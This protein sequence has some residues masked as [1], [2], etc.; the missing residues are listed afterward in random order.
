MVCKLCQH[1]VVP[2]DNNETSLGNTPSITQYYIRFSNLFRFHPLFHILR[3]RPARFLFLLYTP[4]MNRRHTPLCKPRN[5]II[6]VGCSGEERE[7]NK[8]GWLVLEKNSFSPCVVRRVMS[9]RDSLGR[10]TP[11]VAKLKEGLQGWLYRYCN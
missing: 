4:S 6:P 11:A 5:R 7:V 3:G 1:I 10:S 8:S 9:G 2:R